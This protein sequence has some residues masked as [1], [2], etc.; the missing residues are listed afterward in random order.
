MTSSPDATNGGSSTHTYFEDGI[1]VVDMIIA[2][3]TSADDD[4]ETRHKTVSRQFFMDGL[5]KRGLELEEARNVSATSCFIR[6]HG[7]YIYII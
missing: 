4:E 3:E 2:F 1:R 5:V 6:F 7:C